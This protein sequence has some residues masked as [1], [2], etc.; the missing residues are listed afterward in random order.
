MIEMINT[1]KSTRINNYSNFIYKANTQ[2]II[3][4]IH[5]C[6]SVCLF[7]LET[8]QHWRE[9][10]NESY[11]I[12]GQEEVSSNLI[13]IELKSPYQTGLKN[14]DNSPMWKNISFHKTLAPYFQIFSFICEYKTMSR[15]FCIRWPDKVFL[16]IYLFFWGQIWEAGLNRK[17]CSWKESKRLKNCEEN[18]PYGT[19]IEKILLSSQLCSLEQK[20]DICL[21]VP[22]NKG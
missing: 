11:R 22:D 6:V 2:K 12:I 18:H 10:P 21:L 14:Q 3:S 1:Y 13:S 16:L 19:F 8:S 5:T 9:K 17:S 7:L 15:L 4:I 20:N